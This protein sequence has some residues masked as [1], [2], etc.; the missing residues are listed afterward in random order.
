MLQQTQAATVAPYFERFLQKF[1]TIQALADAPTDDLMKQWEGL[2]YYARA[3]NLQAAAKTVITAHNGTLPCTRAELLKLKGFGA[4]TS[5]S[6]ASLA[7]GEDCAAIDGNLL[8]VFAR[9]F[10][11]SDDIRLS[12][13]KQKIEAL[14]NQMLPKGQAGKFNEALMELGATLCS[15]KQP[16]CAQCPLNGDCLAYQKHRVSEFPF[17]SKAPKAP[18]H[19][20][21]VG[22]IHKGDMVLIALRPAKGLL[23][24]LWEFPGGKKQA[25]ETLDACCKREIEE[26]TGLKVEVGERFA[27]VKH[28]Y[29]HFKIT[30][31]AFH[32]RYLGGDAQPKASQEIRW[33][34][35][36][37][38]GAYAFPKANLAVI[39]ALLRPSEPTL[40]S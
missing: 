27:V 28:A 30:L 6:V 40:F 10:A 3:R 1:P 18:H 11:I 2:G 16:K 9:V 38:L 32:C 31:N 17:K 33:A 4:Y 20:I 19:E 14:A 35:L 39:E 36:S 29:T 15:P 7:F 5:A 8:R 26:E 12:A 24:N 37:E 13:T 21:A 22:V 25:N 23:G 34:R